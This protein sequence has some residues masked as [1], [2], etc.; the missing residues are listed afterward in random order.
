MIIIGCTVIK[1][2]ISLCF[3]FLISVPEIK[4]HRFTCKRIN[5]IAYIA[6]WKF[7]PV[8]LHKRFPKF[9]CMSGKSLRKHICH[10]SLVCRCKGSCI[11]KIRKRHPFIHKKSLFFYITKQCINI[12]HLRRIGF[13][14]SIQPFNFAV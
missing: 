13:G 6:L 14:L 2:N 9:L 5:L 3:K 4:A 1:Q 10:T 11:T 7:C 12:Q 8:Q